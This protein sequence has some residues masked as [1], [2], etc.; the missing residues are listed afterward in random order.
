MNHST[1]LSELPVA[2]VAV[3]PDVWPKTY[4]NVA[5]VELIKHV[6]TGNPV[7]AAKDKLPLFVCGTLDGSLSEKGYARHNAAIECIS[8]A[9]G[10]HDQGSMTPE[11]AA[12]KLT[13][14]GIRAYV[15]TSPSHTPEMPRWRVVA[16]LQRVVER[17]GTSHLAPIYRGLVGALDA[18]LG[19]GT[20]KTESFVLSQSF[21]FGKV[22]GRE[23]FVLE[24]LGAWLDPS[25]VQ[26]VIGAPRPELAAPGVD[27]V[28]RWYAD[29]ESGADFHNSTLGL[30]AHFIAKGEG[31]T[32][33]VLMVQT[34]MRA[35]LA[36]HD[37]R[38]QKRYDDIPRLAREAVGKG[39]APPRQTPQRLLN[40]KRD[41][42][43]AAKP[44]ALPKRFLIGELDAMPIRKT[45][46][47]VEGLIAPGLTLLAAPPKQ[48][49]SYL[50]LQMCLCVAAGKP[51]LGRATCGAPSAY[52]DLEEWHELLKE[53]YQPIAQAHGISGGVRCVVRL[54]M[55]V[56]DKALDDIAEEILS[57]A[58]LVVVD[59]LV[60][61]RDEMSED[62]RKNA[63]ARDYA[64]MERLAKFALD[65]PA[66][67]I[68]VVHHANKGAHDDWQAKISGSFG[69][70][71][72]SH[73][74]VYL[75]RPDLRGMDD[76][77]K[78]E[79]ERYRVLHATGKRVKPQELTLEMMPDDG[80]W[81]VSDLKP[82]EI[83]T[84]RKQKQL[85][86]QMHTRP[87]EWWT[88]KALAEVVGWGHVK[89][90]Q[91]LM[92]MAARNVIESAGQ[93]GEG[94]RT[95]GRGRGEGV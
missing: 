94:Y 16:P 26:P 39:F 22:E 59:L 58:K 60:K 43:G 89:T 77:D 37:E 76:E 33:A 29:I 18:A 40:R 92:R 32:R 83:S 53:R 11:E 88:A 3:L 24:S 62:A 49:K 46:W 69:L 34:A 61:I 73:A 48:G 35:S 45:E 81:Q 28:E 87:G 20:L 25:R 8:V 44:E 91:L 63:Y 36:A 67:A 54:E 42:F 57:G 78:A 84:T 2:E 21:Y 85:L 90:R 13:A 56:G 79:A 17:N 27:K 47:L 14:A 72:A 74:N 4:A 86:L 70:T 55:G 1:G 19:A 7:K 52:F 93:G 65:N 30:V 68:V 95:K 9:I 41:L 23:Y 12:Q 31:E 6:L 5:L 64:A 71:A 66:I 51:F 82:W 10:D 50:A 75:A 15:Y 38:W 80:G